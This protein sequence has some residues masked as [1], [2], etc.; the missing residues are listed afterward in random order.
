M[1]EVHIPARLA[2][3]LETL[4]KASGKKTETLAREAI[5]RA[6]E[7]EE[8]RLVEQTEAAF[9]ET[10]NHSTEEVLIH[11]AGVI[12]KHEHKRRKVA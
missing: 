10:G 12:R 2:K 8:A 3:R 9:A 11:L 5:A 1:T 7:E 4:A 6:V